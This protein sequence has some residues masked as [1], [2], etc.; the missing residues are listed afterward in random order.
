[1]GKV[2]ARLI[3]ERLQK[4]ADRVLPESLCEFRRGRG[5]TEM[6]FIVGQLTEKAIEH[7][8]SQY[9]IFIDLKKAYNLVL[10]EAL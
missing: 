6:I 3:Q 7:R 8:A 1:M 4:L 5:C 9:L 2:V 10:C